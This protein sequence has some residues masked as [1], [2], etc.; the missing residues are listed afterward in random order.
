MYIHAS[1]FTYIVVIVHVHVYTL[2]IAFSLCFF[3]IAPASITDQL[4]SLIQE[5][6][7]FD[8]LQ[9][10][11]RLFVKGGHCYEELQRSYG[12][13]LR[14]G[15]HVQFAEMTDIVFRYVQYYYIN[16]MSPY[17]NS[18]YLSSTVSIVQ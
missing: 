10:Q 9:H 16:K 15:M 1:V 11:P 17:S 7:A 18:N 3:S 5:V 13:K 4:R 12:K 6:D 14:D 2:M 8:Q